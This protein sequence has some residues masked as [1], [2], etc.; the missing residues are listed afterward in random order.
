[1][2][3]HLR[4]TLFVSPLRVIEFIPRTQTGLLNNLLQD[5][6]PSCVQDIV[7][8]KIRR[9]AIKSGGSGAPFYGEN[10]MRD[11]KNKLLRKTVGVLL[12]SFLL[13]PAVQSLGSTS[14]ADLSSAP[15]DQKSVAITI[16]NVNLGLVRDRRDIAIPRGEASL[17]FG[18]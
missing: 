17:K 13:V 2:R 12:T 7:G 15:E 3:L 9:A 6:I 14:N 5:F 11:K 8:Q 10:R 1:I 16:Y 4:L 18:G